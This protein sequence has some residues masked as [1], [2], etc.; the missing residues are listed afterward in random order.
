M[1]VVAYLY[2][3]E[4]GI[5]AVE[6]V[7][8]ALA[9]REED[10]EHIDIGTADDPS[11]ARREAMLRVGAAT[12]IGGKPDAIFDD[13]GTPDFAAGALITEAPTGRRELHIGTDA[14]AALEDA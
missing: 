2:N 4:T 8:A 14:V 9:D 12:R 13:D 5:D 7:L 3:S 1:R 11:A 10:I 6:Q